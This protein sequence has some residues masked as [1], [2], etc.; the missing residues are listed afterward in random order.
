MNTMLIFSVTVMQLFIFKLFIQGSVLGHVLFVFTL[1]IHTSLI[2]D[3][4]RHHLSVLSFR[5]ICHSLRHMAAV[6]YARMEYRRP[7]KIVVGT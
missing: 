7:I 6:V 3:I 5:A 2:A 1:F 4:M